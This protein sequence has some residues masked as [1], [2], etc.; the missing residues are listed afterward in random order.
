MPKEHLGKVRRSLG[1]GASKGCL[2][3]CMYFLG[4]SPSQQQVMPEDGTQTPLHVGS[5]PK[6]CLC[7]PKSLMCS[8]AAAYRGQQ[9]C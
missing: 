9:G 5:S 8:P 6:G 2:L 1:A 4:T 3:P 7:C